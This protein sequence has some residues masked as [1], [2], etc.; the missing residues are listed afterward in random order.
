MRIVGI[1]PGTYSFD[2]FGMEDDQKVIV[3]EAIKTM[4]ILEDPYMLIIRFT[5]SSANLRAIS[6]SSSIPLLIR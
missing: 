1:D 4:D 3:D 2:L 5:S 6:S